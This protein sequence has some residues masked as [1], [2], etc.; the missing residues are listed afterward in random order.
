[1]S[2]GDKP[3]S[4]TP[5]TEARIMRVQNSTNLLEVQDM[6]PAD[7]ARQLERELAE[8][9]TALQESIKA[10]EDAE[11]GA[12]NVQRVWE[13]ALIETL[14]SGMRELVQEAAIRNTA[15]RQFAC[16]SNEL[17][18]RAEKAERELAEWRAQGYTPRRR[19]EAS[20][21]QCKGP[22]DM[23]GINAGTAVCIEDWHVEAENGDRQDCKRGQTYTTTEPK[24]GEVTV[25]STFWVKAPAR[26]FGGWK[27]LG[28]TSTNRAE[29]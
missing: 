6:V 9:R 20:R 28:A 25:F 15:D 23:S 18:S 29:E 13:R 1:M 12:W 5:R 11:N 26:I 14:P 19:S 27:P 21:K 8:A 10:K 16:S 3:S 24:D 7:F 17:R 2:N 4:S 22:R